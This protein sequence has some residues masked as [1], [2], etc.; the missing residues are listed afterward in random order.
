MGE[1]EIT[2]RSDIYALGAM[3]YEMLIGE[4]PFTGPTAQAIVAKVL[5]EEPRAAD[6]RAGARS[7]RRSRTRSSPRWRSCRPTGSARPTSSRRRSRPS[8]R[9]PHRSPARR[10]PPRPPSTWRRWLAAA[11]GRRRGARGRGAIS[12]APAARTPPRSRSTFGQ[13]IKVT[14]DPGLE[15]AAGD[16]ARRQDR[17]LRQRHAGPDAGLRPAGGRRPRHRA[18]RRYHRRSSRIP[19][20]SPDG[21]RVLFLERG[22]VVSVPATGGAETPEVPPGRTVR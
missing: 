7:R 2:A 4:P 5:T 3:T 1:R 15:V 22:G 10:A 6:R 18:H 20:W 12:S 9:P 19:R 11:A 16:L 13:A 21:S 17:R 14:W 8:S